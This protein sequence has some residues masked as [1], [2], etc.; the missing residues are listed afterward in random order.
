MVQ[1]RIA[2]LL[3]AL[4][5]PI[6]ITQAS[7][8]SKQCS[9]LG[10]RVIPVVYNVVTGEYYLSDNGEDEP[11]QDIFVEDGADRLLLRGGQQ[12]TRVYSSKE[13]LFASLGSDN[14]EVDKKNPTKFHHRSAQEEE[15]ET[16]DQELQVWG[17]ADVDY[18]QQQSEQQTL[19]SLHARLCPCAPQDHTYCLA[20]PHVSQNTCG[21]P[22]DS[23]LPVG[24]YNLT[25]RIV[26]IRNAWPV[27]VLW[28]GALLIF[29]IAT[30]NGKS[31]RNWVLAKICPGRN[32][33]MA[34]AYLQRE[35]TIRDRLRRVRLGR[36]STVTALDEEEGVGGLAAVDTQR[37][38]T[39]TLVL[40][41]KRFNAQREKE[42]RRRRRREQRLTRVEESDVDASTDSAPGTPERTKPSAPG[43]ADEEMNTPETM[44]LD[45][46]LQSPMSFP[47]DGP[48]TT[49]ASAD[50]FLDNEIPQS[51]SADQAMMLCAP[52][53]PISPVAD[54][55]NESD[56]DY[57]EDFTCT[58]CIMDVEDGDKVGA[59][60]CHH[61]FHVQCLKEWI[62]R[63]N[64]CP[65][66]QEP[67][68]AS[69]RPGNPDANSPPRSP[70][71]APSPEP[72]AGG[73]GTNTGNSTN[74]SDD[75]N[76]TSAASRRI[77][78][79]RPLP[80]RPP[81]VRRTTLES[82]R[83]RL[84]EHSGSRSVISRD[85]SG[86]LV[87]VSAQGS[88]VSSVQQP[89]QSQSE[90]NEADRNTVLSGNA[91]DAEFQRRRRDNRLSQQQSRSSRTID[92]A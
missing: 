61:I 56:D 34:D 19:I 60:S 69:P 64:V 11:P 4:T 42:K 46:S 28:Y 40:K 30:E 71:R 85:S 70:W 49:S 37:I 59:L 75:T 89:Q 55:F 32:E 9:L 57:E 90:E 78:G 33:R 23:R 10:S 1:S 35:I 53:I 92:D 39:Q 43:D 66:C 26:F 15:E 65:L 7:T 20:Q 82:V 83:S 27:V 87:V 51:M 68:I 36:G 31:A 17:R 76:T 50:S 73:V 80:N 21:I 54:E 47:P 86:N 24:C 13:E 3:L 72:D 63:K 79:L 84:F 44:A 48:L 88:T 2:C 6:S 52:C 41:T 62:K 74:D 5:T 25:N 77:R 58:I 81:L 67:D 38:R 29:L 18:G 45:N 91:D 16:I 22:R 14:A 8:Y 12:R